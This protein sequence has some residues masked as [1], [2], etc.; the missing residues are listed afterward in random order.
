MARDE[1]NNSQKERESFAMKA[2]SNE[3]TNQITRQG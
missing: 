1:E 2:K 3:H